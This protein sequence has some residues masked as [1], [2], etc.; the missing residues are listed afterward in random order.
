VFES[1]GQGKSRAAAV[2]ALLQSV[3]DYSEQ[4]DAALERVKDEACVCCVY[5]LGVD[6][7]VGDGCIGW[8]QTPILPRVLYLLESEEEI[9]V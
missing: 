9:D 5:Q 2:R 1:G 3:R 8:E 7:Y 4:V 6:C